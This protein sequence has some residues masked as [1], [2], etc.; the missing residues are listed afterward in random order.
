MN[1][2]HFVSSLQPG[3]MERFAVRMAAAQRSRLHRVAVFALRGGP[4]EE[5]AARAGV[6]VVV[7]GRGRIDRI[8][9]TTKH[10]LR[11]RPNI[12]HAHNPTS[13]HYA[14][15]ARFVS[16]ARVIMTNHGQGGGAG[17][18][19]TAFEI[20]Q[21]DA[22]VAVSRSVAAKTA[23][24][25]GF[26]DRTVVIHNAVD[27]V[28]PAR[29]RATMRAALG[30]RDECVGLAVASLSAVKGHAVLLDA[31]TR[32]H[33]AGVR[34]TVLLAG[35]GPERETLQ[36]RVQALGL[37]DAIRFL[38]FRR[39]IPDLL[40]AAD[41]MVLPSMMEGLPLAILEGMS[42]GLPVIATDVGGIP[43]LV[44]NG[45]TGLLV[46]PQDPARLADAI[47]QVCRDAALRQRL[48]AEARHAVES[49]FSYAEM[50]GKYEAVY[51]QAIGTRSLVRLVGPTAGA[52]L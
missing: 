20:R 37:Q 50:L 39:D 48:G 9:S 24:L 5:E 45:R 28:A 27:A 1:V 38:G 41:F 31:L 32:L 23:T 4:L 2:I 19:P 30:L 33:E 8:L 17:R 14:V 35:D 47:S 6:P 29:D 43:E 49:A 3:G 13:L 25:E 15:L 40:V 42:Q 21:T 51:R 11:F 44:E 26:R 10:A 22:F 46:P 7:L 52:R 36:Q 34:P 18:T 12:V 16:G